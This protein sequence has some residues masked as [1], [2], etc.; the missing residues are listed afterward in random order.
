[1][2]TFIRPTDQG[3]LAGLS[4]AAMAMLLLL[5]SAIAYTFDERL[6]N[7]INVW[8]KPIKFDLSFAIH[9]FT[10]VWLWRLVEPAWRA[11]PVS[12]WLMPTAAFS[13]LAELLY[14]TL[15]AARGR[16]SHFNFETPVE[17]YLYYALMGGA[18]LLIV[19]VTFWLGWLVW[20]HPRGHLSAGFHIG[21]ALGLML[22]AVATLTMAGALA[23]GNVG[24]PGHWVGGIRDDATGLP[25]F[26]WSTTGG[27]LR[28]PHFFATHLTQALPLAGL[29][30]DRL[31]VKNAKAWL[32]AC[33]VAGIAVVIATFIQAASGRALSAKLVELPTAM[34]EL[35]FQ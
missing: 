33:A 31:Q 30:V 13:S 16:H 22:G 18:A 3:A 28:V 32:A 35:R 11:K 21:A 34:V 15:Q 25:L 29:I 8:I 17:Y 12:Q 14:I 6:L 20:R 26:G 24:G 7:G 5:V 27:D 10:M 9:L 1:M 2:S 4:A 19:I 23:S